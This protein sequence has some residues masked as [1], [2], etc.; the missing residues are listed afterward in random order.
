MMI[1]QSLDQQV[2]LVICFSR[3]TNADYPTAA[4][5]K[6]TDLRFIFRA[7]RP[8]IAIEH[9]HAPCFEYTACMSTKRYEV[10]QGDSLDI[11][12]QWTL[13]Y[14]NTTCSHGSEDAHVSDRANVDAC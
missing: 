14:L 3:V 6:S 4:L 9:N 1:A 13:L 8:D 10:L 5:D 12:E 11:V 7:E 2:I